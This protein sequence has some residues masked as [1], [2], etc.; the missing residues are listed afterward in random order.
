MKNPRWKGMQLIVYE[1]DASRLIVGYGLFEDATSKHAV[2]VLKEAIAKHG[3][4]KSILSDRGIQF[5]AIEAEAREKGLTM[6]ELYLMKNHIKQILGRVNHPQTNGKIE[7]LFDEIGRKIKFF[8][9]IDE[10]IE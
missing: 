2:D 6:F 8:N 5:Y 3:K 4:P 9:S 10:C 7:K 1:D